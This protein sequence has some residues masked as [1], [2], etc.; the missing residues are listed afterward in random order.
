MSDLKSLTKIVLRLSVLWLAPVL[1]LAQGDAC[2]ET[3]QTA[4]NATNQFCQATGRNQA[5]YGHM[6]LTAEPQ[7]GIVSFSFQQ[8]GDVVDVASV[9]TLR[10]APMDD[11]TGAWGVVLMSL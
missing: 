10:L 9:H 11:N 6:A 8:Q 4:L 3:V 5:C 1:A 7:P 2:P